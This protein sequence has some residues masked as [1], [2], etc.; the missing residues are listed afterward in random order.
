LAKAVGAVV[1]VGGLD[2]LVKGFGAVEESKAEETWCM[3][4]DQ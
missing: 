4:P 2:V 1:N 3:F